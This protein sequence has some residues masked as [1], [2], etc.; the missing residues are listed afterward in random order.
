MA[1]NRKVTPCFVLQYAL[2]FAD[3]N[4]NQSQTNTCTGELIGI[5]TLLVT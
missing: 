1:R 2:N 5:K 4:A 3:G